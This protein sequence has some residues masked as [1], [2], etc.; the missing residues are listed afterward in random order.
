[1]KATLQICLLL[2]SLIVTGCSKDDAESISIKDPEGTISLDI[3][4][5][6]I[7][8]QIYISNGNLQG[9]LFVQMGEIDGLGNITSIPK[10]GWATQVIAME[11]HG[12]IAWVNGIYYRLYLSTYNTE[13]ALV[14]YQRPFLGTETEIIP[15]KTTVLFEKEA[16]YQEIAF[17]NK[18]L[19][20][21]TVKS[22]EDWYKAYPISLI[23]NSPYNALKIVVTA[24]T[25][26]EERNSSITISSDIGDDI[27]FNINQKA[28][29]A[30][31]S[32]E[33]S[34]LNIEGSAST[35]Q[36]RI[37]SNAKW[38]AQSNSTWC[39]VE[40]NESTLMINTDENDSG[41]SRIAIITVTTE[42][43]KETKQITVTQKVPIFGVSKNSLEFEGAID[44]GTFTV[45]SN[46]SFWTVESNQPWCKVLKDGDLITV[47]VDE[48]H[49]GTQRSAI[50]S[51]A[52]PGKAEKVNV[53]QKVPTFSISKQS[54]S[55]DGCVSEDNFTVTSNITGWKVTS[56]QLWCSIEQLGPNI[57]V[58]VSE[59][60]TGKNRDATISVIMPDGRKEELNVKQEMPTFSLST[61]S[62]TLAGCAEHAD[63]IITTNIS[64][65][66]AEAEDNWYSV[67]IKNN[68]ITVSVLENLT[69]QERKSNI[70]L[71][72]PDGQTKTIAILQLMPILDVPK[73]VNFPKAETSESVLIISNVNSWSVSCDASWCHIVRDDSKICLQV[74]ENMSG[75]IRKSQI[76]V[77][78]PNM[79]RT[80]TIQQGAWIIGDYYNVNK[81]QGIVW[82]IDSLGTSGILISLDEGYA[83]WSTE[84]YNIST[85]ED[86]GIANTKAFQR[87]ENWQKKYPAVYWCIMKGEG[88]Y[89]PS[90]QELWRFFGQKEQSRID[91][92]LGRYGT[93]IT[94]NKNYWSSSSSTSQSAFFWYNDN[95][96]HK[97]QWGAVSGYTS[98]YI[99]KQKYIRAF[100]NF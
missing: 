49:T 79:E 13:K 55:F 93:A 43:K 45:S 1:M 23:K 85:S 99:T 69:G 94:R 53:M 5:S 10:A 27:V 32:I 30:W 92:A 52:I 12:Y 29:D 91:A 84:Q 66:E 76:V 95:E 7:E 31:L 59:N 88:W 70:R 21:Y 60:L 6:S 40:Q 64:G 9:A 58:R 78:L 98:S 100:K 71:F 24:N 54:L 67:N 51:V 11:R 81:V 63:I 73:I 41:Q 65:L 77:S 37:S 87:E 74:D 34:E 35:S 17:L 18:T 96:D 38:N 28:A 75:N 39:K 90:V 48:N 16:S 89:M 68:M 33:K 44:S 25:K 2:I 22:S 62:I 15:T 50:I 47:N 3:T 26:P 80:I 20:P 8:N 4:D 72:L 57:K 56:D 82:K 97:Y 14:K 42:N 61:N 46:V 36:I 83:Q 19:F 86:D